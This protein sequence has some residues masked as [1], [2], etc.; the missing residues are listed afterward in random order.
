MAIGTIFLVTAF[1][2]D[3]LYDSIISASSRFEMSFLLNIY[4]IVCVCVKIIIIIIMVIKI[5]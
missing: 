2:R 5:K 1:D 4:T 3:D